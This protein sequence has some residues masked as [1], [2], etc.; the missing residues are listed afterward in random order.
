ML[1]PLCQ[2]VRAIG[3]LCAGAG[4]QFSMIGGRRNHLDVPQHAWL[5]LRRNVGDGVAGADVLG[6]LTANRNNPFQLLGEVGDATT[7]VR[8]PFQQV[9][10]PVWIILIEDPDSIYGGE[11]IGHL[12]LDVSAGVTADIIAAVADQHECLL[13]GSS[14]LELMGG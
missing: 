4:D 13:I 12:L 3:V 8:K 14:P 6:N 5:S 1:L 10:I 7:D 11:S 9:G 2:F